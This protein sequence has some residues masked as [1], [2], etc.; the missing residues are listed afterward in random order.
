MNLVLAAQRGD[1]WALDDLLR[2]ALPLVYNVVGRAL[3]G[4][5]D[6]DDV[7]QECMLRVVRE[8]P[9]LDPAC[10]CGPGWVR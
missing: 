10:R 1:R 8:V 3:G 5:P 4:P 9:G 6:V 2:L 7:V